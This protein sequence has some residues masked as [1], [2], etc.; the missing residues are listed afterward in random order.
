MCACVCACVCARTGAVLADVFTSL[1]VFELDVVSVAHPDCYSTLPTS[2]IAV[3]VLTA[4][5]GFVS[6]VTLIATWIAS[7]ASCCKR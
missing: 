4:V 1:G 3:E 6:S 7:S 2:P 5:F